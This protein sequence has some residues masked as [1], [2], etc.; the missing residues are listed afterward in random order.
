MFGK[1]I[2]WPSQHAACYDVVRPL[3]RTGG[4]GDEKWQIARRFALFK[5]E[6]V[7]ASRGTLRRDAPPHPR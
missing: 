2:F 1:S 7:V 5:V 6:V 3:N 4:W